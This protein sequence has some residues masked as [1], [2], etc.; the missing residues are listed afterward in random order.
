MAAWKLVDADLQPLLCDAT[1]E[2]DRKEPILASRDHL[3]RDRGP[4]LESAGLAEHDI[5]SGNRPGLGRGPST[6]QGRRPSTAALL[7]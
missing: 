6:G 7:R 3:D 1:L 5:A 2:L 4:H